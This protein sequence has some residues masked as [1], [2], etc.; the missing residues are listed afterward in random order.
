[1]NLAQGEAGTIFSRVN[2]RLA[3]PPMA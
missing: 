1:M 3:P 2:P